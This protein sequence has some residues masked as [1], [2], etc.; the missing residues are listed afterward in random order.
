LL[1]LD[2]ELGYHRPRSGTTMDRTR[3]TRSSG[4]V[5]IPDRIPSDPYTAQKRPSRQVDHLA[6]KE[7][8]HAHVPAGGCSRASSVLNSS[9]CTCAGSRASTSSSVCLPRA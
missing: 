9:A 5:A 1:A 4:L 3:P 8:D 2:G 7:R 6:I